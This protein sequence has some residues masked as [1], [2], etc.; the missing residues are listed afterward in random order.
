MDPIIIGS[1]LLCLILHLL[2]RNHLRRPSGLPLP[3]GP[4]GYPVLGAIPLIGPAA[5]SSLATLSKRYGPI[6]YL[7]LGTFPVVVASTPSSARV[8]LTT[9]DAQFA[10]RPNTAISGKDITYN[11]NDMVFANLT[12]RW[13]HFRKL[14]SLHMLNSKAISSWAP[15]RRSE[16]LLMLR[17]I[18][19]SSQQG[20]QVVLPELLVCTLGNIIGLVMLSRRVFDIRGEELSQFKSILEDML[21]GGGIFNIGDFVPSIAWMDLQGIQAKMKGVHQRF[22]GMITRMLAEHTES[23]AERAGRPDFIDLVIANRVGDNGET[24]SDVNIK[25]LIWDMFTAGTDTSS[26]VIEWALTELIKNPSI[27]KRAQSE[28]DVVIGRERLLEE[29][30][31]P[32]L[33]YLQAIC[34]EA[35]RK[36]PSTPLSLPHY[37]FEPC[38]VEGYYI[39][40]NTRLLINIWAIGRDPNVWDE[41]MKFDPERFIN[42]KGAKIEPNG[43]DF[44]LIPFGSGRR[45]CA[46][47]QVGM[48]FLQYLLGALV[49]AFDWAV[50]EGEE[51]DMRETPGLA[52]PKTVPLKAFATPRLAPAAYL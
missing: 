42:G 8:F 7:K 21:T 38:E 24:L 22:D 41:P 36:H 19:S 27:M 32:N 49:H 34:K 20:Q 46:G 33:P 25:G 28:M 3:P 35:L 5:H 16:L 23:A 47:K 2:M 1:A 14:S 6:M 13:K 4:R 44:E 9:L 11:G 51:I 39:P 30:D 43:S 15:V 48:I 12:P 45:I 50:P 31:I 10:N 40:A 29:S 17:S 18:H 26:I 52:L 37:S